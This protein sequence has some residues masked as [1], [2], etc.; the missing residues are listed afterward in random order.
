MISVLFFEDLFQTH[1]ENP[2]SIDIFITFVLRTLG[3]PTKQNNLDVDR[4]MA[5]LEFENVIKT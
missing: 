4:D 5:D 2:W 1:H 3:N